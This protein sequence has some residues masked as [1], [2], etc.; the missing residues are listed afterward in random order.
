MSIKSFYAAVN[1]NRLIL[2]MYMF[3]TFVAVHTYNSIWYMILSFFLVSQSTAYH[4][5]SNI[6]FLMKFTCSR[7]IHACI[8][9]RRLHHMKYSNLHNEVVATTATFYYAGRWRRAVREAVWWLL[10]VRRNVCLDTECG[11]LCSS[12]KRTIHYVIDHTHSTGSVL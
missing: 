4:T 9:F 8:K 3:F 5:H 6:I 2:H 12:T 1:C 10:A 7:N 11:Q